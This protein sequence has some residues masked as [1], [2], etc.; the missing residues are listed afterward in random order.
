MRHGVKDYKTELAYSR[1][2]LQAQSETTK[3]HANFIIAT[4]KTNNKSVCATQKQSHKCYVTA[5]IYTTF[6]HYNGK[7]KQI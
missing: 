7:N 2:H 5:K 6:H 4:A 3:M 1:S